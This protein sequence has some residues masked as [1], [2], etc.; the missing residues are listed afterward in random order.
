MSLVTFGAVAAVIALGVSQAAS[1]YYIPFNFP[2]AG[3]NI[4]AISNGNGIQA[5]W[6]PNGYTT[7]SFGPGFSSQMQGQFGPNGG[8]VSNSISRVQVFPARPGVAIPY[9]Y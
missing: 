2:G 1:A 5:I 9:L 3:G 4:R 6:G 8:S 7:T